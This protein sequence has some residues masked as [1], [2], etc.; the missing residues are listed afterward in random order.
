MTE[1]ITHPKLRVSLNTK[2]P[3]CAGLV[4]GCLTLASCGFHL[5]GQDTFSMPFSELKLE[6][7]YTQHWNLC[8]SVREQLQ[9][10]RVKLTDNAALTLSV[11][12]NESKQRV[13]SLRQDAAAAEYGQTQSAHYRLVRTDTQQ[14]IVDRTV[15][16]NRSYRNNA[17]ALLAK[18]RE[19]DEINHQL[20]QQLASMIATQL[21]VYD[22]QRISEILSHP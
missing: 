5:R 16:A 22:A 13:L 3:L 17:N 1:T 19:L 10:H 20:D 15:T 14:E 12:A 21:R 8:Q 4:L 9:I 11:S 18:E 7:S 6:C 2:I